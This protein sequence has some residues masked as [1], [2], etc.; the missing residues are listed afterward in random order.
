SF[1]KATEADPRDTT[2]RLNMGTV[3]LR[4][5]AY[6]KAEEQFR[7]ILQLN[8]EDNEAAVGLAASLRGEADA[9]NGA[10]LE[11][12]RSLL[13]Q[14]IERDP[15]CVAALFNMGVL[16]FD[17]LKRPADAIA[18]FKRF[19]S[20]APSDHPMRADAERYLSTNASAPPPASSGAAP[21][22]KPPGGAK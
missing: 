12:A 9:K 2:A 11:Q 20:D 14:G 21:A 19:L 13:D 8:P 1:R 10:K 4:A 5:G 7:A 22:T 3:L 17:F 18:F 6:A 15:H 16:L